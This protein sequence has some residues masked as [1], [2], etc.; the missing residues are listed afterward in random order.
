M[1]KKWWI[2]LILSL[3]LLTYVSCLYLN[4][5]KS[6]RKYIGDNNNFMI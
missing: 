4:S 6:A 2:L 1:K 5:S 3:L